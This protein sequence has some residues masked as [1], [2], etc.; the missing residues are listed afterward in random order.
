MSSLEDTLAAQLRLAGIP[1]S[2]EYKAII[3]RKFHWDFMVPSTKG[4]WLIECQGAV[5][6]KGAHST[7][8]GITRDAVKNNLANLA[9]YHVLLVTADHIKSGQALRWIQQ[10]LEVGWVG[11]G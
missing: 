9:G 3:G 6:V 1:F 11:R 5:W 7:G 4:G 10:A 8:T 2:R